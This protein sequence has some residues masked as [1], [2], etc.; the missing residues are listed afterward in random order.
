MNRPSPHDQPAVSTVTPG[1]RASVRVMCR[2]Y[3]STMLVVIGVVVG[4]VLALLDV[5]WG[6]IGAVFLA[7][8]FGA[9]L[10]RPWCVAVDDRAPA[11][12]TGAR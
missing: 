10:A 7:F 9:V 5:W 2:R 6:L 8:V 11:R 3:T 4:I 12:G 1:R